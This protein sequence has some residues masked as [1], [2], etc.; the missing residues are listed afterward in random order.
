MKKNKIILIIFII[1]IFFNFLYSFA[2]F[3][4]LHAEELCFFQFNLPQRKLI[5]KL[6]YTNTTLYALGSYSS[7]YFQSKFKVQWVFQCNT[8]LRRTSSMK[9]ILDKV[10]K[11]NGSINYQEKIM[12]H[13]P[14]SSSLIPAPVSIEVLLLSS[15][16]MIKGHRIYNFQSYFATRD[17]EYRFFIIPQGEAQFNLLK[18]F[19]E[20]IK[21]EIKQV[22]KEGT[23]TKTVKSTISEEEYK[24]R[25]FFIVTVFILA[26][27]LGIYLILKRVLRLFQKE[28]ISP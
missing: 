1:N 20:E 6:D 21:K 26:L 17:Y 25:L 13:Q 23:F 10:A 18:D 28:K 14:K 16:R 7:K 19:Q 3:Q 2:S 9:D 24:M 22:L 5:K 12:L 4:S 27:L 11:E 15:V 8:N